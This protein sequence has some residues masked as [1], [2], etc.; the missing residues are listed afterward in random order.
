MN[1]DNLVKQRSAPSAAPSKEDDQKGQTHK[2]KSDKYMVLQMGQSN[3]ESQ[4][5]MLIQYLSQN[6]LAIQHHPGAVQFQV[7]K[8]MLYTLK[9]KFGNM[10]AILPQQENPL[11]Y[12]NKQ[13]ETTNI[14]GKDTKS[15]APVRY[16]SR[17]M[18]ENV[19]TSAYNTQKANAFSAARAVEKDGSIPSMN[20]SRREANSTTA[21]T[22]N[23]LQKQSLLSHQELHN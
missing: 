17:L 5:Q 23:N 19:P 12:L 22:V 6:A 18:S 4:D 2:V 20:F 15:A 21:S 11:S 10:K 7:S 1:K 13:A 14:V 16:Q 9:K 3:D 8:Q